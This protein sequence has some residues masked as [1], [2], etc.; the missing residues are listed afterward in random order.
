[1]SNHAL[2]STA[3]VQLPVRQAAA[4]IWR[5]LRHRCSGRLALPSQPAF[6]ITVAM[7]WTFGYNLA[8]WQQAIAAMW[9][10]SVGSLLFFISLAL[11]VVTL[12]VTLLLCIPTRRLMQAVAAALFI[13]AA[14]SSHFC[15]AYGAIF[16][17]DMLRNVLQTDR[18]EIGGLLGAGSL[19]HFCLLGIIPAALSWHVT[20]PASRW[21]TQLQQRGML[22]VI[23][24]LL[25]L[26]SMVAAAASYA[27]FFRE[28]KPIRYT[29][30]PA[31][32]LA[33]ALGLAL[34]QRG[35]G[36]QGP[37]LDVG[38]K[39]QHVGA[40][41]ARPLVIFMVVGET[42]RA[43]SFALGGY[44]RPTNP[45][46]MG[47]KSVAYFDHAKS[48]GTST[49]ISVPC[50]FS[51]FD[52]SHFEVRDAARYLNLLDTLARNGFAVEWRDNNAGCKGVCARIK[53]IQYQPPLDPGLCDRANCH[54][55]IML[56]DL[57]AKLRTVRQD[58]VI[59]FHQIGSH[60]PAYA[61]RYPARF[62]LFKPACH[63]KELQHCS[64]DE[65]RNAYDNTIVYTD[66]VLSRQIELLRAAADHLDTVLIYASDHGESLGER[67]LYLHGMPYAFAPQQQ[68]SVPM[69]IWT[70]ASLRARIGLDPTCLQ[71]HAHDAVSHD[72][73]YHTLLG[74]A[75]LRNA[76]YDA[77]LDLTAACRRSP[78]SPYA[79]PSELSRPHAADVATGSS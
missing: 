52:R 60:G 71:S 48:C 57:A 26:A 36:S 17:Q 49:A 12:H 79:A 9:Q 8:F 35:H 37:L 55:E 65:V 4:L 25:T 24:W 39:V 11:L 2:R 72:N 21:T 73:L 40:V 20:L 76:V 1:M 33:S 66:Y 28:Y 29:A 10:P 50:M 22:L 6:A 63:S 77:S 61:E 5:S 23:A 47:E 68:K 18:A 16:N 19:L 14:P 58:S 74:V 32:P 34:S 45:R 78:A 31:A 56:Q 53:T 13:V 46:L 7:I 54:D 62:E 59:V 69:L 67:G 15:H 51:P 30:V 42:A 75:G 44:Q 38:G 3:A 43:E 41:A 70:S 27:V 64:A